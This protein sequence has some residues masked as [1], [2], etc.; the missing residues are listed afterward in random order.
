MGLKTPSQL[1]LEGHAGNYMSCKVKADTIVNLALQSQLNRESQWVGKSST[2]VQ[3]QNIFER[4]EEN[5]MIP[6]AE[7][8][9]NLQITLEKQL[10]I[11]KEATRN[12]VQLVYLN[13]WNERVKSLVMQGDFLNLLI[14]EQSLGRV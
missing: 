1:Y 12:E 14:S 9:A 3:C 4:V 13:K 10:P 5:C 6:T 11:L 7:N 8:C 2:I